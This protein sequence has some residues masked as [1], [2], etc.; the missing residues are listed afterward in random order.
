MRLRGTSTWFL[1][2]IGCGTSD[3][4]GT[5]T[6]TEAGTDAVQQCVTQ[7]APSQGYGYA[8]D[9]ISAAV[10]PGD[11]APPPTPSSLDLAVSDCQS[12]G[13]VLFEEDS[14]MPAEAGAPGTD[15]DASRVMTREAALCVARASGL[16]EGIAPLQAGLHFDTEY[17]RIVWSVL[18]TTQ[19]DGNGRKSGESWDIDAIDGKVLG[20]GGWS[21]MP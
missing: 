5:Q 13:P 17:R 1:L 8:D 18:N 12:G 20:R 4:A 2:V 7:Y 19:D 14:G 21:Q 16:P 11:A 15:C 3:P 10:P 9:L 6:S